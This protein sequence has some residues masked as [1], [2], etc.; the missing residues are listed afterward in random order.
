MKRSGKNRSAIRQ[1][2]TL[3]N[4]LVA[5]IPVVCI[6]AAVSVVFLHTM[7]QNERAQAQADV[8][9][10]CADA[11]LWISQAGEVLA[12]LCMDIN[13]QNAMGNY[14]AAPLKERLDYRDFFR[15]RLVGMYT[16]DMQMVNAAIY[17]KE[18]GE[19]FSQ[20]YRDNALDQA[21]GEQEWFRGILAG[22]R[23]SYL[24]FGDSVS[25]G[26]RVI[27]LARTIQ[28]MR[29]GRQLGIG[30]VEL[31]TERLKR[32]FH[33]L[34]A[35]PN[36][37]VALGEELPPLGAGAQEEGSYAVTGHIQA[38]DLPVR[39]SISS[40]KLAT[41]YAV[42]LAWFLAGMSVLILLIYLIDK[43]LADSFTRRIL[44]QV[45]ATR[46]MAA[47]DLDI[48]LQDGENDEI[49]ELSRSMERTAR[50]MKRLIEE[51]YLSEI[52]RQQASL[53][54]LQSQIN[55]HFIFN[56]LERVS[57]LALIHD[58]YEIVNI[59][60]AFSSM[61]RYAIAPSGLVPLEEEIGNVK[62]YIS[63][64]RSRFERPIQVDYHL[65]GQG[66]VTLPRLTLQ[67]LVE[68]AFR[69]GFDLRAPGE[70][71]LGV[72]VGQEED[73][74]QVTVSNNGVP[75]PPERIREIHSLLEVPLGE[76]DQDCFALRNI[77][78]RMKLVYG[79]QARLDICSQEGET[80]VSLWLPRRKEE[81]RELSRADL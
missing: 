41:A 68:N 3:S 67:P 52:Q 45:E 44:R 65:P 11:D 49:G 17:I 50:D 36:H 66:G 16:S 35:E 69:H 18:A 19:T 55:P 28:S 37:W 22:E 47:G 39:Y 40:R 26:R 34:V 54:A 9:K 70:M 78:Q 32:C 61:M 33:F 80:R 62:H 15:N 74:V 24:G 29:N 13:T 77:S 43:R 75:I 30:Y 7:T 58:Q 76:G 46:R 21:L 10:A 38:L 6:F 60:Q 51:K 25:D 72:A 73:G 63:I 79:G 14:A 53:H 8:D 12:L 57:M 5:A 1:K 42:A 81:N 48:A 23:A 2:L 31:S 4:W 27:R 59:T 20:D 71:R 64:Q 56:T